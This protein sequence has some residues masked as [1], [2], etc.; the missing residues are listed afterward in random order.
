M[1]EKNVCVN[2]RKLI[3]SKVA[4]EDIRYKYIKPN[5]K[6]TFLVEY[7]IGTNWLFSFVIRE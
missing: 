6:T 7:S 4:I 1:N 5:E 2:R 3:I